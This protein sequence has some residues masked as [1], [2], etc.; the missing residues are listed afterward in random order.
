[1]SVP[2]IRFSL[3]ADL[4]SDPRAWRDLALKAE[5]SGFDALLIGDHPGITAA[6]FAA[7]AAAAAATSS[8]KVGT[9]VLNAGVRDPFALA[10]DAATLDVISGGRFIL[11]LGA[12]HTPAEWRMT[13]LDYPSPAA[14]AGRLVEMVEVVTRLLRGEV[15]THHGRYLRLDDA[16]LS[17]PRPVQPVIP[18]LI[19]GNGSAVLRL[20]GRHADVVSLS[21]AQRTLADGHHHEVD[22]T[23]A[24]ISPRV[25]LVRDASGDR[26]PDSQPPVLDALVQHVGIT[27]DRVAAAELVA[28]RV[29]GAT[30]ADVLGSPFVLLGTL[31]ELAEEVTRHHARWG[32]TSYVVRT[33]AI[34]AVAAL[35]ERLRRV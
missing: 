15:V 12:G 2:P 32:F 8:L 30:P 21:G 24:A 1:M 29:S 26:A 22:W 28:S 25:A 4:D 13:G 7:L 18:L 23:N 17:A 3:Q 9:Y 35:I 6:P 16:L 10:S 11:G 14:R 33:G 5:D 34:D 31:D 20:G 19:G 27:D